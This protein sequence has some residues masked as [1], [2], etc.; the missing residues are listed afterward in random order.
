MM[1]FTDKHHLQKPASL[2]SFIKISNFW[3]FLGVKKRTPEVKSDLQ[4]LL[5]RLD[6]QREGKYKSLCYL[7]GMFLF[8]FENSKY[9]YFFHSFFLRTMHTL[10]NDISSLLPS[11]NLSH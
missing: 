1:T 7:F 6:I 3:T 4:E 8:T 9:M 5:M 2:L 10:S 11:V